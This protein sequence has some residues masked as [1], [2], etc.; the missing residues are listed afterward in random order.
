MLYQLKSF[1]KEQR[2]E[3]HKKSI[4]YLRILNIGYDIEDKCYNCK[5]HF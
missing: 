4:D 2:F 5:H 3:T 1:K